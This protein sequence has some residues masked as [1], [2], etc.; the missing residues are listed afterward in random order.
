MPTLPALISR[1]LQ[2]AG[3]VPAVGVD[4][5]SLGVRQELVSGLPARIDLDAARSLVLAVPLGVAGVV[6]AAD[7]SAVVFDTGVANPPDVTAPRD[8]GAAWPRMTLV[9]T[10]TIGETV[11]VLLGV[12][13][14]L[15][16]PGP[17]VVEVVVDQLVIATGSLRGPGRFGS[18]LALRWRDITLAPD[19]GPPPPLGDPSIPRPADGA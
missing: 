16:G 19:A 1:P 10:G 17:A 14:R 5:P 7:P 9:V 3:P 11:P 18:R 13:F 4:Q 15:A 6:I 8:R 2:D 12:P